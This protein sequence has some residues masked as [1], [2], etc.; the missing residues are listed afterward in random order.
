MD[1][2]TVD[3]SREGAGPSPT[4]CDRCGEVVPLG[5]L[6]A[7]GDLLVCRADC[8]DDRP[9]CPLCGQRIPYGAYYGYTNDQN[10]FEQWCPFCRSLFDETEHEPLRSLIAHGHDPS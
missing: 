1:A 8:P 9:R 2:R 10:I 5:T 7:A 3:P 6:V 4:V